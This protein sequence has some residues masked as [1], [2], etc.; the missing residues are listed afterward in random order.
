MRTVTPKSWVEA[1]EKYEPQ[2]MIEVMS[3][4]HYLLK[5]YQRGRP[6]THPQDPSKGWKIMA[7]V[8][9]ASAPM[10]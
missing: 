8:F 6:F 1:T 4:R 5:N 7:N 10:L 9:Y 2:T 3:N